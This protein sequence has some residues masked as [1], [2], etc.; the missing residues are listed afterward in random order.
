MIVLDYL[1][2]LEYWPLFYLLMLGRQVRD[3]IWQD[4][5]GDRRLL[6]TQDPGDQ[7]DVRGPPLLHPGGSRRS[8]QVNNT[9]GTF[10]PRFYVDNKSSAGRLCDW[11]V[12]RN[13][14]VA[15]IMPPYVLVLL[16]GG[17]AFNFK[18]CQS[19]ILSASFV[20]K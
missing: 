9:A 16:S 18:T 6:H 4:G 14:G 15:L 7:A 3:V 11:Q 5:R 13:W 8:A 19:H 2:Y 10:L 17:G 1:E 20:W 12:Y